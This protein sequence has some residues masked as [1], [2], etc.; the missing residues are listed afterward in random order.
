MKG[1]TNLNNGLDHLLKW[2][3]RNDQKY[4]KI[5]FEKQM[6]SWNL[7]CYRLECSGPGLTLNGVGSPSYL[8]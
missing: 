4:L 3:D 8:L 7:W 5:Y 2:F 6:E 1:V